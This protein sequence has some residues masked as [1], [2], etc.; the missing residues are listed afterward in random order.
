MTEQ[1]A[2]GALEGAS[3]EAVSA[4]DAASEATENTT[5]LP[6]DGETAEAEVEAEKARAEAEENERK[7]RNE[8]R[9]EAKE[10]LIREAQEAEA[11]AREAEDHLKAVQ[12]AAKRLP[13][14]K[15]EDYGGNF[16]EYQAALSAHAFAQTLD[17]RTAAGIKAEAEAERARI[18]QARQAAAQEDARF[19]AAQTA[20]ARTRYADFDQVA[21]HDA[22]IDQR[23]AREIIQSDMAAD[24][25]YYLGKN[26]EVGRQIAA[27]DDRAMIRAIGRIEAQL[28]APP[29]PPV[30]SAPAPISPVKAKATPT[31]DV[32]R[33]SVAEYRAKRA[34]GWT[35]S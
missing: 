29:K 4:H 7:S 1:T 20:E 34:Q 3:Q 33:M 30:T 5:G 31:T 35:P 21:L 10:R 13:K 14:P 8:R 16:E 11:R 18:E 9:R 12:E 22:P 26:P 32:S 27:M 23:M 28:A 25:A 2:E 6:A 19:W 24:I 17:Q 15:L